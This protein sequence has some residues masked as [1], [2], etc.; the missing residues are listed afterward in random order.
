MKDKY[1]RRTFTFSNNPLQWVYMKRKNDERISYSVVVGLNFN[2]I[3]KKR[4]ERMYQLEK[5]HIPFRCQNI[6]LLAF[7]CLNFIEKA[8]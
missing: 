8:L 6:V 7:S 5:D 4:H 2:I 1:P 3:M